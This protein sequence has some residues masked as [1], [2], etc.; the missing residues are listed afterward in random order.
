MIII[1]SATSPV[2]IVLVFTISPIDAEYHLAKKVTLAKP[3]LELAILR[4]NP[5]RL[6]D[7]AN[8]TGSLAATCGRD[9]T[10]LVEIVLWGD[11]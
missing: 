2:E 6:V 5:R 4:T 9:E 7:F 3:R 10:G 1:S 11:Q 8:Y